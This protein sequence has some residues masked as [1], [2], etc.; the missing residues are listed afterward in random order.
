[1]KKVISIIGLFLIFSCGNSE[2]SSF[3]NKGQS[4]WV[5]EK[6]EYNSTS[7]S[8][9]FAESTDTTDLNEK[10]TWFAD[11]IGAFKVGDTLVFT[12]KK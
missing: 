12:K 9:Y 6:I 5:V 2:G 11:T 1:M 7:T 4:T 10:S 8:T 3:K